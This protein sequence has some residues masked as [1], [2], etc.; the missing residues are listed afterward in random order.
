MQTQVEQLSLA[1]FIRL[2]DREGPFEIIDGERRLLVPPV[3]IHS[4]IVRAFFLIFYTHCSRNQLGEV[5]S[6][7]T[8][9]LTHGSDWVRGS[10]VPD[11]MFIAKD[12]WEAYLAADP[13]AK[14]KP[15][16]LVP[17]LVA[18]VVSPNDLYTD[19]QDKVSHYLDDGVQMVWVVDP[20]RPRVV[21][22]TGNTYTQYAADDILPGSPL[23]PGLDINLKDLFA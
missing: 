13:N 6:E 10:R 1:E 15:L 22:Y 11:L 21:T 8:F 14:Q 9:V 4:M 7:T 12:R 23:L 5:F 2:Y 16:V 18:E 3:L 17:D 20:N 19:L